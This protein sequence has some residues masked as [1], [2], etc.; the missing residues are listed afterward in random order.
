MNVKGGALNTVSPVSASVLLK[1]LM[2]M[3]CEDI[4]KEWFFFRG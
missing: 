1:I 3:K 4:S 2:G